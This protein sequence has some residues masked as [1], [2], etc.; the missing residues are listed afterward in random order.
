MNRFFSLSLILLCHFIQ[1]TGSIASVRGKRKLDKMYWKLQSFFTFQCSSSSDYCAKFPDNL[2]PIVC[3]LQ[4]NELVPKSTTTRRPGQGWTSEGTGWGWH[5]TEEPTG[6]GWG[7]EE[8]SSEEDDETWCSCELSCYPPTPSS[9]SSS[10]ENAEY[11]CKTCGNNCD[12]TSA[13][14][15]RCDC[16]VVGGISGNTACTC[17][18]ACA[19]NPARDDPP[20]CI[21]NVTDVTGP[22]S[23]NPRP[24]DCECCKSK[25][26]EHNRNPDFVC[27]CQRL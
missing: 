5:P 24:V 12:V 26:A 25:A 4:E 21:F 19:R 17:S 14:N 9:S 1:Y 6:W 20:F 23:G 18:V 8:S 16:A 2:R 3:I 7:H 22:N 10:E 27:V 15:P 11:A 13:T